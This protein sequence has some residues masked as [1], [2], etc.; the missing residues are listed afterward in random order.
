M[1]GPTS[2]EESIRVRLLDGIDTF[3][4]TYLFDQVA[5]RRVHKTLIQLAAAHASW[6]HYFAN[7]AQ[8]TGAEAEC[9]ADHTLGKRQQIHA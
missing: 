4:A 2:H 3:G 9:G 8:Q 7:F 6:K 1:T 5:Q